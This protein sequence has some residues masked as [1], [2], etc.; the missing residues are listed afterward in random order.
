MNNW[1]NF[2]ESE[3]S[4]SCCGEANPNLEFVE[5]MD[6]VQDMRDELGFA[7]PISSAYR[8][9]SHPIEAKKS[10]P[11]MHNIAAVDIKVSGD[12]AHKVLDLAL[13]K[14]FTGIGVNQKGSMNQRFIHLDLRDHKTVWSY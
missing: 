7:L 5:L 2:T 14:G 6:I 9:E 4:C 10:K 12:K 13:K 8:C 11:G 3:L 1:P